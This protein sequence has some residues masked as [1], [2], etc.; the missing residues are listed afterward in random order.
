MPGSSPRLKTLPAHRPAPASLV[1]ERRGAELRRDYSANLKHLRRL[2]C[3]EAPLAK[4][5]DDA[6]DWRSRIRRL[7]QSI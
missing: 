6:A 7:L 5:P 3:R 4:L 1:D 2:I